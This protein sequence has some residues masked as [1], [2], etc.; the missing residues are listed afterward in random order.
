VTSNSGNTSKQS[1]LNVKEGYSFGL[2]DSVEAPCL[3][4]RDTARAQVKG[5]GPTT[6]N[7]E[8]PS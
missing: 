7:Y 1:C 6:S 2:F 8:I 4:G 5:N 3:I